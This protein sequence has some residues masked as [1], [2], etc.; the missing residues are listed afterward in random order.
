MQKYSDF[1]LFV[2]GREDLI[3]SS[4]QSFIVRTEGGKK[5]CGGIGDILSGAIAVC[6]LWDFTYGPVLASIIVKIA[7]RLA[8]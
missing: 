4:T 3:L 8:F 5:R 6:A 7:A 1:T 2:K